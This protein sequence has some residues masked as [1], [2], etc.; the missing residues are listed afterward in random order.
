MKQRGLKILGSDQ[1][2]LIDNSLGNSSGVPQDNQLLWYV[3]SGFCQYPI[4]KADSF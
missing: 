3:P 1:I 2:V 4:S